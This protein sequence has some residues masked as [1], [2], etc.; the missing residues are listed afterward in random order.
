MFCNCILTPVPY[1]SMH[2]LHKQRGLDST[3]GVI[4]G[5]YSNTFS[6]S[7]IFYILINEHLS[8][9]KQNIGKINT[10]SKMLEAALKESSS[11]TTLSN[12]DNRTG[13]AKPI[14]TYLVHVFTS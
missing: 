8:F 11:F 9:N 1:G 2:K 3:P 6:F 4:T 7:H 14:P 10:S 5:K 13:I 12:F